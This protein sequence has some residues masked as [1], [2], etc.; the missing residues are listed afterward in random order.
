MDRDRRAAASLVRRL[1]RHAGLSQ[2]ALAERAGVTQPVIAA[3]ES[4]RRQPSVPALLRLARAAG[5]ELTLGLRRRSLPDD[6]HRGRELVRVLELADALPR[7]HRRTL[8]FPPL[9]PPS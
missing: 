9:P 6:E 7:R 5:F 4:G 8:D 1:R 2:R 3:Y